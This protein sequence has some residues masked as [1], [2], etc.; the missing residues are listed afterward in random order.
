MTPFTEFAPQS[1]PPGPRMT[2]IRAMSSSGGSCTSHHTPPNVGVYAS[3]PSIRTSILLF[4]KPLKPRELTC[5]TY[6][7][8]CDTCM[9][10]TIRR[11]SGTDENPPRRISSPVITKIAAGASDR[12]SDFFVAEVTSTFIRSS[13]LIEVRSAFRG[14]CGT[15]CCPGALVDTAQ[16]ASKQAKNLMACPDPCTQLL[17]P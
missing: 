3:L 9:P 14:G 4:W 2:S 11:A 16:I 13:M 17:L 8:C 5:H 7:F 6:A 1:V 15:G 12:A 10:G